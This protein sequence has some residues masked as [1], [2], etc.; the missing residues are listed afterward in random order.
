LEV[1]EWAQGGL[2]SE[3]FL[4]FFRRLDPE[5][6]GE[7]C[8]AIL[9]QLGTNDAV[10]F[11]EGRWGEV[12]FRDRIKAILALLKARPGSARPQPLIFLA[13]VPLFCDRPESVG[14]NRIV[15]EII[16][17]AL[18]TVAREEGA[19]LVD[20]ASVLDS[21]PGLLDPD[22]V[23]PNTKGEKALAVAWLEALRKAFPEAVSRPPHEGTR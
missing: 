13:T 18:R 4:P 12:E 1:R 16:N 7:A 14:K 2:N 6:I 3:T 9:V 20:T 8:D 19:V 5:R 21:R 11:L 22:C 17:P 10:P 15:S 23:H